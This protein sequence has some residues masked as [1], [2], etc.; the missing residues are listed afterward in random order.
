MSEIN[1]IANGTFTIGQTSATSF[2][3]GNGIKIDEPSEGT[4]R[5]GNDETVLFETT[6]VNGVGTCNLSESLK[7]FERIA[8]LGTRGYDGESDP[9]KNGGTGPWTFWDCDKI[10]ADGSDFH[11]VTP[12]IF[13]GYNW[14]NSCYSANS[15][16]TTLTWYRG[17]QKNMAS[18]DV[19]TTADSFTGCVGIKKIIG[20]NRI[21]GSNA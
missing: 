9:N 21:S 18:N 14:K 1:S 20:I 2:I 12:F 13:E 8:V 16:F 15:S 6:A 11:S 17:C 10:S 5:I 7:N 19:A 3:A 4:V